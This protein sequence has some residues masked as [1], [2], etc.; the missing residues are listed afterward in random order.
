MN[1]DHP[2]VNRTPPRAPPTISTCHF[3]VA[4]RCKYEEVGGAAAAAT[5][6]AA[7]ASRETRTEKKLVPSPRPP[8]QQKRVSPEIV[9]RRN[10]GAL[11]IAFCRIQD[12]R[13]ADYRRR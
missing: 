4:V 7:N 1:D 11:V 13:A 3:A 2:V 6:A 9:G 10:S 8:W 5:A 12:S